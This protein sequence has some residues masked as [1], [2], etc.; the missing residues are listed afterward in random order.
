MKSGHNLIRFIGVCKW[1]FFWIGNT[2]LPGADPTWARCGIPP[3]SLSPMRSTLPRHGTCTKVTGSRRPSF[4]Q[5][6]RVRFCCLLR[7]QS[8]SQHFPTRVPCSIFCLPVTL[9]G[10]EA[11]PAPRIA[12]CADFFLPDLAH[13]PWLLSVNAPV[14]QCR[15]TRHPSPATGTPLTP[16]F[17]RSQRLHCSSAP[18]SCSQRAS[19]VRGLHPRLVRPPSSSTRWS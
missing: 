15:C 12:D 1:R 6:N 18:S 14:G 17:D 13:R 7:S 16:P 19:G 10:K 11:P 8:P 4:L 9:S 5:R 3:N 2:Q